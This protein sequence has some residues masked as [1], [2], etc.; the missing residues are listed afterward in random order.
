MMSSDIDR[1][2]VPLPRRQK[3]PTRRAVLSGFAWL[4][5][6]PSFIA[7]AQDPR[8]STLAL[9]ENELQKLKAIL[10]QSGEEEDRLFEQWQRLLPARPEGLQVRGGF[11]HFL[12]I[13]HSSE[14]GTDGRWVHFYGPDEIEQLRTEPQARCMAARGDGGSLG[15]VPDE[16]GQ[17]YADELVALHDG[18]MAEQ[19]AIRE[20]IGLDAISEYREEMWNKFDA[21]LESARQMPAASLGDLQIKA[22]LIRDYCNGVGEEVADFLD[23]LTSFEPLGRDTKS[24]V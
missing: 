24:A 20:R 12:G 22:R 15:F 5:V 13:C 3:A 10:D 21:L 2:D 19:A 11:S 6:A 9:V 18:W 7:L 4:P 14:K 16:A 8:A 17:R 1:K 23:E